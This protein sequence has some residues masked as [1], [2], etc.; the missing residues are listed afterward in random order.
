VRVAGRVAPPEAPLL[1]LLTAWLLG[2]TL[3]CGVGQ[4]LAAVSLLRPG[5]ALLL[6][7]A[8]AAVVM[9]RV[10]PG[11]AAAGRTVEPLGAVVAG[12]AALYACAAGAM[13]LAAPS[14]EFETMRYHVLNAAHWLD[15]GSLWT[16]PLSLP[17]IHSGAFPGNGEMVGTA[18]MW[19]F[20]GDAVVYVAPVLFGVL[21]A[22]AGAQLCV[23]LDGRGRAGALAALAVLAAPLV[24][25]T[26]VDSLMVDLAAAGGLAAALVFT[27]HARRRPA[28]V[29]WPLLAGLAAGFVAG[30]KYTVLLPAL[31][32]IA[33]IPLLLPAG[34]RRSAVLAFVAGLLPLLI[35]WPL[36]NLI[37]T[38]NPLYPLGLSIG[39]HTVLSGGDGP[40]YAGSISLGGHLLRGNLAPLHTWGS[41]AMQLVGA[42]LALV[43]AGLGAGVAAVLR[44]DRA[45]AVAVGFA[46]LC[47]A[48]YVVTPMTGGGPTGLPAVIGSN[49]R[50]AVPAL[51]IAG[52]VGVSRLGTAGTALAGAALLVDA[53]RIVQMRGDRP[54]L[55]LG[56]AAALGAVA[57]A[58]LLIAAG[59]AW[60]TGRTRTWLRTATPARRALALAVAGAVGAAAVAVPSAAA[61]R[62]VGADPVG[63]MVCRGTSTVAV[64]NDA[65][66]RDAAGPRLEREPLGVGAGPQGDLR[67]ITNPVEFDAVLERL[68]PGSLVVGHLGVS[69]APA[70][71]RPPPPWTPVG[72]VPGG[73]LYRHDTCAVSATR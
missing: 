3:V 55:A 2:L 18:L 46:L 58:G 53:V 51:L 19:P 27:L 38:G 39:G 16:L 69:E 73:T 56:P 50:Y 68:N 13:G 36:R 66:V 64:V 71:W 49:L 45:L 14:H 54:E 43:A 29:R 10:R 57:V 8:V 33:A 63:A 67:P 30:S 70:G 35:A 32:L 62:Q 6:E 72:R 42:P 5:S 41:L 48:V 21:C 40:V 9:L 52:V 31:G 25:V 1:R 15:G 59:V 4:A 17:G 34:R 37:A 60:W 7:C 23:E 65:D 47:L 12:L 20:H 61:V 44:R 11:A 24:F 28:E 26:Q 22:L